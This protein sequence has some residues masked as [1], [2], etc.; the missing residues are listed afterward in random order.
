MLIILFCSF[1]NQCLTLIIEIDCAPPLSR[2][3]ISFDPLF[4]YAIFFQK[5][6]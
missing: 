1:R 2:A 6:R 4:S 5:R 3:G